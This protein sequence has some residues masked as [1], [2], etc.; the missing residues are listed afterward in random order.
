M[1][2]PVHGWSA[3]RCEKLGASM[4]EAVRD[5]LPYLRAEFPFK[6]GGIGDG[7]EPPVRCAFSDR[8][9]YSRMPLVTC[10]FV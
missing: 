6:N 3:P 1:L 2:E 5:V 10:A 7:L 4:L 8:I 9:L